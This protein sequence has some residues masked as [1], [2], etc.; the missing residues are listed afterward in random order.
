MEQDF[1]CAVSVLMPMQDASRQGP[2][3]DSNAHK[4]ERLM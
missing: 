3:P 4:K 1:L 2:D